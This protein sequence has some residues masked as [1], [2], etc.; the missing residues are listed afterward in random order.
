MG[1]LNGGTVTLKGVVNPDGVEEVF[2]EIV[3]KP[4]GEE[5]MWWVEVRKPVV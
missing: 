3:G 4:D 2:E 1:W 5:E